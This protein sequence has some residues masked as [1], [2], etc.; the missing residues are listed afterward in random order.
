M[1]AAF[2]HAYAYVSKALRAHALR[3]IHESVNLLSGH[4]A[5][6][7]DID[8][9]HTAA[10]RQSAGKYAE[11]AV[12]YDFRYI[13]KLHAETNIRLIG[14]VAIHRLTV[15]HPADRELYIHVQNFLEE[16]L[17][18]TLIDAHNSSS[19]TKESSI[20]IWVKSG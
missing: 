14:A 2:T 7:L 17:Q 12:L 9:A 3:H 5:L 15:R 13:V 1:S 8:T 6:T 18:E 19:V 10:V 20:S 11:A 16:M 4:A